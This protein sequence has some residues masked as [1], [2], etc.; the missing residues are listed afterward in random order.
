MIVTITAFV[1]I[2]GLPLCGLW[3]LPL[4][5]VN[6]LERGRALAVAGAAGALA[7]SVAMWLLSLAGIPWTRP[8]LLA[9]A[10]ALAGAGWYAAR[11]VLEWPRRWR[12]S[13]T[14][15]AVGLF[16]AVS[17]Y[18]VATVRSSSGDLQYF[19]GPK[20]IRF[21]AAQKVDAHFL[22][23]P[24]YFRLHPDYPPLIPLIYA[25]SI[26]VAGRFAWM[27]VLM[28]TPVLLAASV[29]VIHGGSRWI[30]VL[31]AATL[32]HTFAVSYAAGGADVPL[33]FFEVL[34]LGAL[35]FPRDSRSS[36][37]IAAI[38]IAGAVFSKVEGTTFAIAVI[39]A[40]IVARRDSRSVVSMI[41]PAAVLLGSWL[42][43]AGH[44]GLI[45]GYAM[46]GR[47]M[48]AENIGRVLAAVV[49][50]ASYEIYWLPWIAPLVIIAAGDYRRAFLPLTVSVLTL[51]AIVYFYTHAD[52]PAFWI[53]SSAQRVLL[54]PLVALLVA[55]AAAS[56]EG[57]RQGQAKTPAEAPVETTAAATR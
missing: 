14:T 42:L 56:G 2:A 5:G 31:S 28:I 57:G 13:W 16:V 41:A 4:T 48:V 49:W 47:P 11:G 12:P 25:W 35:T 18:G 54:T 1:A 46:A 33:V 20:A 29:A 3:A 51:A 32:A 21:A 24:N 7:L 50:A 22:G 45:D 15:A 55:A 38:G 17:A 9:I 44:F 40:L 53:A 30:A 27:A 23:D 43:F 6:V 19:W 39:I 37:A 36:T 26:L 8:L 10:V 34:T 52:D